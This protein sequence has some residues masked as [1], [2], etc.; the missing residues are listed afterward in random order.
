[1][2]GR[3][4]LPQISIQSGYSERTLKRY[5][6]DYLRDAPVLKV[7]PSE[8]VNLLI[9]GTYFGRDL[10]LILYRDNNIKYTQLYRITDGEWY[11]ELEEDLTN[12][13]S[14]GVQIE[15]ITCD[16]HKSLLKA[17]RKVCKHVILQ[18]CVIH[19]QRMCRIW[20]TMNPKS[21]PGIELRRIVSQ[22]HTIKNREDWGYW[23][24]N[25]NAW[26]ERHQDY[27]KEKSYHELTGRYWFKHKMVRRAFVVLK[28]AIPNM[29]HY[30][31]NARIPKSTNGLESFFGHLKSHIRI[32]R[33]LSKQNRKEFLKWYLYFRNQ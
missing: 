15:S 14:L 30:L 21:L 8:K 2:A 19:V 23:I 18:R 4:T 1:V 12:L 9:D 22:L 11:E 7:R 33:G 24:V 31:D 16:G 27:L 13:L 17:V 29:F 6:H 28:R 10:C 32:H 20:L 5:F 3:Q 26:H 25:L